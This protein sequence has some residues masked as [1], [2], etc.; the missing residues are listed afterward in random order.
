[1]QAINAIAFKTTPSSSI[2]EAYCC[3]CRNPKEEEGKGG[4]KQGFWKL[5]ISVS[6]QF[7]FV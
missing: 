6:I 1:M 2:A 7:Q 5:G 4:I 3:S